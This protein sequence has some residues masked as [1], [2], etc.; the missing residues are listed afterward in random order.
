M[1]RFAEL[2]LGMAKQSENDGTFVTTEQIAKSVSATGV[3]NSGGEPY[4]DEPNQ[5]AG[6]LWAQEVRDAYNSGRT[7]DGDLLQ[8]SYKKKR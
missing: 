3:L 7:D 1:G 6:G 2:F 8:Y 5:G 4:S